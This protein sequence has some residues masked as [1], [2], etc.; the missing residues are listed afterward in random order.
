[1]KLANPFAALLF[2]FLTGIVPAKDSDTNERKLTFER[3]IR[4]ILKTHCFQCHGE[5]EEPEAELD[6]RLRRLI[7]KGGESGPALVAG[8]PTESLIYQRVLEGEMP[9]GEK[10]VSKDE[11][12]VIKRWIST[13]AKTARPES[14]TIGIGMLITE[15]D[16]SFW[17]F[18]PIR[19]SPIPRVKHAVSVRNPVDAFLLEKLEKRGFTFSPHADK[20]TLIRRATFDLL[21]IPPT[22]QELEH[23]FADDSQGAFERLIERLLKSPHYGERWG[24]H[25][26]DVAGYADSEGYTNED[27]IRNDAYKYRDYVI[28]SLNA[29]KPFDL[30]IQEQLAGDEMVDYPYNN[31][32]A[33][34]VEKLVA[35]GFLRTSPDGTGVGSV[36]QKMA[37]NQ[38]MADT[39]QIVSSSLLGLTVNCAQCHDHRYDP[40]QQADYYRLRAIFEPAYDWKNWRTP[41]GRRISLYTDADREKSKQIEVKAKKIDAQRSKKQQDYINRTYEKELAKIPAEMRDVVRSAHDTPAAKRTPAQKKLLKEYPSVSVTS[42][43]LYLYDRKAADVLKKMAAD[44][45]TI[46]SKKPK[47][48]FIRSLTEIP[49]KIPATFLFHHGDPDQPKQTLEPT[50]L[51][52]LASTEMPKISVNDSSLKTTGRRLAY[53]QLLTSGKHP[54]L[55]RVLVNRVWMHHFGRGIVETPGNFGALGVRPTHPKLLD[56]LADEFV[57]SGWSLKRLHQL[58]MLS[59]AY[60]QDVRRD[61]ELLANDPDNRLLGGMTSRRLEAEAFRDAILAISGKFNPKRFGPAVPVMADRVGQFVVG[62]ENLNAGRPGA[63]ISLNGEEYRRS[64]Y[65]QIRRSRPLAV[66]DTFDFPRMDPNC[67]A[68]TAS[69]VATQSLMLLNNDF[70]VRQSEE[71]AKRVRKEAGDDIQKQ[72]TRAWILAFSQRPTTEDIEEAT[73]YLNEQKTYFQS[74]LP[75]GNKDKKQPDPHQHALAGFCQ[76]LLSSNGFLYID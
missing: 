50:E 48:E 40:I 4:K 58:M 1:M 11:L 33:D 55:S 27:P 72:I 15:E 67:N 14:E 51:T 65:V 63:V 13:G 45:A 24:R 60:R 6:L 29:D 42:G 30:F 5:K 64:I 49:G 61:P 7:V 70:V 47:E 56:W 9:P 8:N 28:R 54:L 32:T 20:Q 57:R 76:T 62:K 59:S 35:T 44:A 3:D 38:V 74:K 21:G 19:R 73:R 12:A 2:V 34:E 46:R 25:W 52:V 66:L 69:T 23:F 31:L 16:R 36:D 18:Q 43:S 75:K 41:A 39:I 37:R 71:F 17:S 22:P 53:A 26:L 68:R 10:K